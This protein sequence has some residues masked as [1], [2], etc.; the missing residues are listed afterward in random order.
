MTLRVLHLRSSAGWAGPERHL[1]ELG[2]ALAS[3]RIEATLA[4][5]DAGAARRSADHPLVEAARAAGL[6][7][8]ALPDPRLGVG[9][10]VS[11][12]AERLLEGRFDLLHAHDY[13]SNW[14]G[15]RA[16]RR[17]GVP[18]VATVH[19][20]TRATLRLRLYHRLDRRELRRFDAVLAVAAALLGDLPA[21][22]YGG[23]GPRVVHNGL[24]VER[25]RARAAAEVEGARSLLGAAGQGP[26]VLAVGRL[27]PQKGFDVLLE[28]VA[29]LRRRWPELRL[30]LAGT[31][32]E[33][34][35]IES[36]TVRLGL[37]ASVRLLGERADVAG[38]MRAADLVVLPS[39]REGLPYV[40]LEALALER[41]LVATAAGGVPELVADGVTGFL[42]EP[43]CV[44][45]LADAL[46]RALSAPEGGA[47]VARRG[48]EHVERRFDAATM[49]AR[50]AE[51]YRGRAA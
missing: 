16:A 9:V 18:A 1:L 43:E 44:A 29:K 36:A 23:G 2:R 34:A 48:R 7:A 32:P 33:R 38:L 10:A 19:L 15:R 47:A 30:A 49:A 6:H 22:L 12:L 4:V 35:R 17:A 46:E 28:A 40:A 45:S 11:A 8:I 31:G 13:K 14:I 21:E 25:L 24:D 50:T 26:L 41:P 37:G 42:A 5:F 51:V 27:T 20:H 39:R 3:E